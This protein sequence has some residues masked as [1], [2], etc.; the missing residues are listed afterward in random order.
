MNISRFASFKQPLS[1]A[2]KYRIHLPLTN[3][4]F[5]DKKNSSWKMFKEVPYSFFQWPISK[6][7]KISKKCSVILNSEL[8]FENN[9]KS[10]F[11]TFPFIKMFN[12]RVLFIK[13]TSVLLLNTFRRS[14]M[15]P[16]I[17]SP[18]LNHNLTCFVKSPSKTSFMLLNTRYYCLREGPF[19]S[20]PWSLLI[21]YLSNLWVSVYSVLCCKFLSW[22]NS[23]LSMK[24]E[25]K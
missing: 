12:W 18:A 24:L 15:C 2:L 10:G 23:L 4:A 6:S 5:N 19:S 21:K 7:V 17:L 11:R 9:W 20:P 13:N 25:T 22:V 16:K 8:K 1:R 14:Q 3:L